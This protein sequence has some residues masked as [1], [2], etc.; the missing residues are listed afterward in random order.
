M[1][2]RPILAAILVVA[3]APESLAQTSSSAPVRTLLAV[4]KLRSVTEVPL[5]F[6]LRR[7]ELPAGASLGGT[8][9]N[10]LLYSVAGSLAVTVDAKTQAL[11]EGDGVFIAS[12]R[13]ASFAA[14]SGAPASFLHFALGTEAELAQPFGRAPAIV[15]TLG[16]S[17]TL[18]GLAPGPHEFGLTLVT[19]P[20][21]NR[22]P[23]MHHRSGAAF[24]YVLAGSGAITMVDRTEMRPSGATQFEPIDFLH[25][26]ANTGESPLLLL[27]ANISAEGVPEIIFP[28]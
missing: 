27:Q 14:P 23:P 8:G 4:G 20:R 10:S 18:S 7:I 2:W 11:R 24:Y 12:G 9:P 21:G 15:T 26:W 19:V 3:F 13:P 28:K 25:T 16:R 1:V 5:Q 6:L 17:T 22:P